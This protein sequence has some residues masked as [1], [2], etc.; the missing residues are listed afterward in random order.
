[1]EGIV[2]TSTAAQTLSGSTIVDAVCFVC[3]AECYAYADSGADAYC[4]QE[5]AA[6][7][8]E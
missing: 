8:R 6:W 3:G 1:V 5:C 7:D 2:E 4:S